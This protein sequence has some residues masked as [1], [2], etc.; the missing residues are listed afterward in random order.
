MPLPAQSVALREGG[1]TG[2]AGHA[3]TNTA[4]VTLT[5]LA[6]TCA[7]S[8]TCCTF[9]EGG[10]TSRAWRA[11]R[12][13]VEQWIICACA[14]AALRADTAVGTSW[15]SIPVEIVAAAAAAAMSICTNMLRQTHMV[16]VL[17]CDLSHRLQCMA[18]THTFCV[19]VY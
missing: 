1:V 9:R 3:S 6:L 10:V 5:T 8:C 7:V 11:R 17:C 15:A 18:T 12:T 2:R 19:S 14:V 16:V 4:K 13:H